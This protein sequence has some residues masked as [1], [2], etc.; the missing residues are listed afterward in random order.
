MRCIATARFLKKG[1]APVPQYRVIFSK[2]GIVVT[3]GEIAKR[4]GV[5]IET[6]RYYER[7][8][9]IA[10]PPRTTSGYRQYPEDTIVR[11]R[12]IKRCQDLGF[13]LKEVHDLLALRVDSEKTCDDVRARATDKLAETEEKI[14]E[15]QNI[16]GA[17]Q[18]MIATCDDRGPMREC[19]ILEALENPMGE[20]SR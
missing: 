14:R 8:E 4:A 1:L 6:L 7:K 15:L 5:N 10:S 3:R 16:R 9:L 18:T 12:F 11:I 19:P 17:L 20:N 13:S 2:K